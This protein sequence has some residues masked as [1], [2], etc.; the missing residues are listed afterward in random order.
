[1]LKIVKSLKLRFKFSR[2]F[3]LPQ[4]SRALNY[5]KISNLDKCQFFQEVILKLKV[6]K[7]L[8]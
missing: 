8:S 2:F 5:H 1:M 6:K 4:I 3:I 7:K